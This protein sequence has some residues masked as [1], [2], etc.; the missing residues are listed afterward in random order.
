MYFALSRPTRAS[1]RTVLPADLKYNFP[2][3]QVTAAKSRFS[4]PVSIHFC[5]ILSRLFKRHFRKL[6]LGFHCV[7]GIPFVNDKEAGQKKG[8]Y[9]L[10]LKGTSKDSHVVRWRRTGSRLSRL[11]QPC[12]PG[13]MF[14]KRHPPE[15]YGAVPDFLNRLW[16]LLFF[17]SSILS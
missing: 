16:Q 1:A 17:T 5:G 6:E 2:Y 8:R 3:N 14:S 9:V 15:D 13:N 4:Q 11:A 12:L 7:P 10:Q